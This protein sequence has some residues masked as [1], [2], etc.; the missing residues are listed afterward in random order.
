MKKK[1]RRTKRIELGKVSLNQ[2]PSGYWNIEHPSPDGSTRMKY[3]TGIKGSDKD[4]LRWMEKSDIEAIVDAAMQQK[5]TSRVIHKLRKDITWRRV[6]DEWAVTLE[7]QGKSESTR[8]HYIAFVREFLDDGDLWDEHPEDTTEM[9]IY[10]FVNSKGKYSTRS[11]KL[12]SIRSIF[13]YALN[14]GHI[15]SNVSKLVQVVRDKMSQS[16]LEVKERKSATDNDIAKLLSL[17][18]G[19][20]DDL[21]S[22]QKTHDNR[23]EKIG[24]RNR[25]WFVWTQ[26]SRDRIA[27]AQALYAVVQIGYG[28]GLRYSDAANLEWDSLF[29]KEG[30]IVLRTK[31]SGRRIA[32]PY[33]DKAIEELISESPA[34]SRE[35]I[36]KALQD[37][38]PY[39]KDGIKYA[40]NMDNYDIQYCFPVLKDSEPRALNYL[41]KKSGLNISFHSLRRGRIRK[42]KRLGVGLEQIGKWVGHSSSK[43]TEVYLTN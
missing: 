14:K 5:L 9:P 30:W 3:S 36:R 10:E 4:I 21:L 40:I 15:E 25:G 31:K 23:P 19:E 27:I 24:S 32:V 11:L 12:H 39:I 29:F 33:Q 17:I 37:S 43:T 42:W 22:R 7:F 34:E 26:K 38:A 20:I 6:F 16:E 18:K 28:L 8:K 35:A 41:I 2:L 13:S 1:A